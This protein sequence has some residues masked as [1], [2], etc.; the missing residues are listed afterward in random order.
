MSNWFPPLTDIESEEEF[1]NYCAEIERDEGTDGYIPLVLL[2]DPDSYPC[3]V[4]YF[5]T[6]RDMDL[7]DIW[8]PKVYFFFQYEDEDE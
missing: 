4:T 3:K 7:N 5:C 8:P 2:G 1:N 6:G